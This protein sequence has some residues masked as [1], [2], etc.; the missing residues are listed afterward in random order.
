[1]PH[2]EV[3]AGLLGD[4]G[5]LEAPPFER[6]RGALHAAPQRVG[7]AVGVAPRLLEQP[8]D[9]AGTSPPTSA[10]SMRI[11]G[12]PSVTAR[13]YCPPLPQPPP[14]WFQRKSPAM[15]SM[16]SRVWKRLPASTTSLNSSATRSEEHTSELQ[17]PCNLVCRLLLEKKKKTTIYTTH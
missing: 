7:A 9:H 13:G 12:A 5:R 6:D 16:R 8:I 17:S 4:P 3:Y 1:M 2:P 11:W 10:S 15:W 14:I